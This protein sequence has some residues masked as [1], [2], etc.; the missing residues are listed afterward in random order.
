VTWVSILRLV[1]GVA[2]KLAGYV[3]DKQLIDA[4]RAEQAAQSLEAA[5]AAIRDAQ[6]ARR[7]VSHDPRSVSDDPYNRD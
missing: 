1:L 2:S 5:H 6:R 3:K 7:N 4:G